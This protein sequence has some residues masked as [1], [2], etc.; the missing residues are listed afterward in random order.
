VID[1]ENTPYQKERNRRTGEEILL[2][3]LEHLGKKRKEEMRVGTL[4]RL[5]RLKRQEMERLPGDVQ[6]IIRELEGGGKTTVRAYLV[7]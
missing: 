1:L 4:Q 7:R 6:D 3:V 2:L 5:R